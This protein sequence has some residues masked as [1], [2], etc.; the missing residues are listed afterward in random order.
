MQENLLKSK[1][2]KQERERES[3]SALN[4]SSPQSS[5][6]KTYKSTSIIADNDSTSVIIGKDS[7]SVIASER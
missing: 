2:T 7:A 5:N 3:I 4:L 1:P 6:C